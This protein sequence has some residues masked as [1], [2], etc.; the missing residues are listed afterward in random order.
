MLGLLLKRSDT[1]LGVIHITM[2]IE[3]WC[4]IGFNYL[5]AGKPEQ[6]LET[7]INYNIVINIYKTKMLFIFRINSN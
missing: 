1:F 5:N 4:H 3:L 2:A 7:L 6:V